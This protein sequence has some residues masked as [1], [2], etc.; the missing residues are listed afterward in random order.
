MYVLSEF[1]EVHP[2]I[3][4]YHSYYFVFGGELPSNV[5]AMLSRG[6]CE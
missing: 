4:W 5:R 3:D 6:T 1:Y 2:G